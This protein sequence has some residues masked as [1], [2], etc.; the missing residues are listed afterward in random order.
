MVK[1]LN[2]LIFLLALSLYCNAQT[3][4]QQ[5]LDSLKTGAE[6]PEGLQSSRAAVFLKYNQTGQ[7]DTINWYETAVLIHEQFMQ[8]YIDAVAYYRWR[9]LN[10]GYD[11]TQSYLESLVEREINQVIIVELTPM[12]SCDI[13]IVPTNLEDPELLD[14]TIPS[15]HIRGENLENALDNLAGIVRRTDLERGNFLISNAP[16][17][18]YDTRIFVKNRFE[19]FQPDLKL[20]KLAAPL[21]FGNNTDQPEHPRDQELT[22]ILNSQYPFSYEIVGV[23]MTEDLMKKAGFQY[24][25]RYLHAEEKIL[26]TLL[27][28]SSTEELYD[29]GLSYKFYVKHLITGDIYLGDDWDSRPDWQQ[30]LMV[31]LTKLRRALKVE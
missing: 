12:S 7:T 2:I 24:V 8:M 9:D 26:R 19:S 3:T 14:T 6:L 10:A 20:D 29:G 25:L 15:W 16:E 4:L 23:G 30:A 21:F 27:D 28:Y 18:F 11:A 17:F 31:H 13:Y 5:K 1:V 22:R